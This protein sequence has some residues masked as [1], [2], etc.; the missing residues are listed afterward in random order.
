MNGYN[1]FGT[2]SPMTTMRCPKSEKF[3]SLGFRH[4]VI[5][6][7]LSGV[8]DC[9]FRAM[10]CDTGAGGVVSEM[11][12]STELLRG[13]T[14]S[15]RRLGFNERHVGPKIV[16]LAGRDPLVMSDAAQQLARWGV[17]QI[18]INMGCP[19]KKVTGGYSGAAL[20]RD[21]GLAR[22]ILSAV[23]DAV[24]C[25]VSVKTRL[26]WE[27]EE[28]APKL[29]EIAQEIGL[30]L[31][32][33]HGRTRAQFYKGIANWRAVALVSRAVRLPVVVNGDIKSGGDARRALAESEAQAVMV[34]RGSLGQPWVLGL[35]ASQLDKVFYKEPSRCEKAEMIK[36]FYTDV[37]SE[38]GYDVGVRT[39]RKHLDAFCHT[40]NVE[41]NHRDALMRCRE[42]SQVMLMLE[43]CF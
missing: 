5:L 25:H 39:A 9:S 4:R 1:M 24:D 32:T 33:V 7:P 13:R 28:T 40:L 41:K 38:H 15:F 22:S 20:L 19:A 11:I 30:D 16:Q 3:F 6:A 34:G 8:T 37:L 26:G 21:L 43:E 36:N 42:A 2:F 35:I 29:A 31:I 27:D 17:D 10:A 12:A 14:E 18:D 23:R